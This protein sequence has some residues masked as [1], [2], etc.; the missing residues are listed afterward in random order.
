MQIQL[1]Q[2]EIEAALKAFISGQGIS[3]KGKTVAMVFT[4]GRG[5]NGLSVELSIDDQDIP[6]FSAGD[7]PDLED[8]ENPVKVQ[9]EGKSL[10]ADLQAVPSSTKKAEFFAPEILDDEGKPTPVA[11]VVTPGKSFFGFLG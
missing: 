8:P 7:E 2:K 1:K 9:A 10:P 11:A 5:G 3:L 4:S 6:G